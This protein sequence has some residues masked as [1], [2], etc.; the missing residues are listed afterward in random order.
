MKNWG[1]EVRRLLRLVTFKGSDINPVKDLS[2]LG[3]TPTS[4]FRT[5]KHQ[6]AL[7]AQGLTST[8]TGSHPEGD[9]LDFM[10]PKGMKMSEAIALVKQTYP[11]T[12]VS[13]SNK[14]ALHITFPGWGK[15]PDVSRSR[16][17]YGD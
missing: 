1:L 15:A 17:R 6:D 13:A 14:G 12:R 16:E 9:A 3:F 10:P 7:R 8:K 2:A 11:G 4:G 5:Q